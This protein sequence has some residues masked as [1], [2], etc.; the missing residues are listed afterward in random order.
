MNRMTNTSIIEIIIGNYY[1]HHFKRTNQ[2]F[3]WIGDFRKI[4][5]RLY[6]LRCLHTVERQ[7]P[8]ILPH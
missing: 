4:T 2:P 6:L 3:S 7:F 8:Y 5:N 1:N